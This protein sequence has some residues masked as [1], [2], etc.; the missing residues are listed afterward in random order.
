MEHQGSHHRNKI[1]PY[2]G[3]LKISEITPADV[4]HWQNDIQSLTDGSGQ[5]CSPTHLRII[6]NQLSAIFNHAIRYY[7]KRVSYRTLEQIAAAL[8]L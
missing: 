8:A 3:V 2:L 6:C 5:P 7:E 1:I 4:L